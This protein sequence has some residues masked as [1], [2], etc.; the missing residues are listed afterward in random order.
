MERFLP[1]ENIKPFDYG[2]ADTKSLPR[3]PEF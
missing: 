2:Y 3:S 1:P